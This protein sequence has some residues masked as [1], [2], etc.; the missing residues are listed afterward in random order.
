VRTKEVLLAGGPDDPC[1]KEIDAWAD[2]FK[3]PLEP[4][5]ITV[6]VPTLAEEETI[7]VTIWPPVVIEKGEAGD[8]VTPVGRPDTE[9]SIA[10]LNPFNASTDSARVALCPVPTDRLC[11]LTL[12][13]KL[14]EA[15]GPEDDEP[16]ENKVTARIT[17]P[18]TKAKCQRALNKKYERF[19]L[20]SGSQWNITGGSRLSGRKNA[21][22]V[23]F[24]G[25][26]API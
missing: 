17:S 12:S 24:P 19:I 4:L 23:A 5:K 20:N 11:G 14:G 7:R 15:D 21:L 16:Q 2:D 25:K 9:T 10:W 6:E 22:L 13:E 3:L 26:A 18:S 8:D 1:V